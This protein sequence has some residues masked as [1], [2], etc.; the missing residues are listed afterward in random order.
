MSDRRIAVFFYGLFMDPEVLRSKGVVAPEGRPAALEGFGLRI[1][2]R[3]TLVPSAKERSYGML[4]ELT[5][6]EIDA[7]YG[8]SGL[9]DY[10]P[11]AVPCTTLG[12]EIVCALCYTLPVAP[13]PGEAHP[14]YAEKL[15]E[16]LGRLGFPADY[17]ARVR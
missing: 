14:E 17:I 10:R 13:A 4:M 3:A 1:G 6:G 2:R 11:E 7:L 5:A 15:R 12:G 8:A 16:V 9:E